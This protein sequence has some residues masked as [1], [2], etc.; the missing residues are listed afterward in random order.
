V[1]LDDTREKKTPTFVG[2]SAA[3]VATS[4]LDLTDT[5]EVVIP[6]FDPKQR[7]GPCKW[8][9][10]GDITTLPARGDECIIIFDNNRDIWI[11][12]WWPF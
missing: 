8:M 11:I 7:W 9:P 4:A 10:R 2:V 5:V 12:G 6:E 3:V 1:G